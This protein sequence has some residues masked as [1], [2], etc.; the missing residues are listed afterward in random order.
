DSSA[1]RRRPPRKRRHRQRE[2]RPGPRARRAE[3]ALVANS[4]I[5]RF[6]RSAARA[7]SRASPRIRRSITT[8]SRNRKMNTQEPA[9]RLRFAKLCALA[10]LFAAIALAPA[11]ADTSFGWLED[12]GLRGF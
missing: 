9:F 8:F 5:H 12:H 4:R 11:R 1:R 6:L 2:A 3:E 7:A 10:N